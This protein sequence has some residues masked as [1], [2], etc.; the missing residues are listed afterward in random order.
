MKLRIGA[1]GPLTLD[2]AS[3]DIFST[4]ESVYGAA[5][6]NVA[7]FNRSTGA[8]LSVNLDRTMSNAVAVSGTGSA[9][10]YV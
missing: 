5:S 9:N 4:S 8:F 6:G 3:L 2:R 10:V 1:S 7:P